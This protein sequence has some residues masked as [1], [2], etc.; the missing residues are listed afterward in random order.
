MYVVHRKSVQESRSQ[1][2][3]QQRQQQRQ[4]QEQ[5][6][7]SH[8]IPQLG[9]FIFNFILKQH[10]Q[11]QR[12]RQQE[13]REQQQ[14]RQQ[15]IQQQQQ[16]AR[17]HWMSQLGYF[18]ENFFC[19]IQSAL[20]IHSSYD[21]NYLVS[22]L[23]RVQRDSLYLF[24][25]IQISKNP[26]D[27]DPNVDPDDDKRKKKD[28]IE[29]ALTTN[30]LE[31]PEIQGIYEFNMNDFEFI[32]DIDVT[33]FSAVKKYLHKPSGQYIAIKYVNIPQQGDSYIINSNIG[34]IKKE[35][36][37]LK[38][39]RGYP[40]ITT[41]YGSFILDGRLLICMEYMDCSLED[42]YLNEH[43]ETGWFPEGFQGFI[44]FSMVNALDFCEQ[45]KIMHRDVK[46]RNILVKLTTSEIKLADFGVARLI[47]ESIPMS[48]K[49]TYLYRA[50]ELLRGQ[51]FSDSRHDVWSF[52]MTLV[53]ASNGRYPIEHN[54]NLLQLHD[55]I[56]NLHSHSFDPI[57][58][59]YS[60][61]FQY[62]IH[63][64]L[65]E[66]DTRPTFAE[67]R[68]TPFYKNFERISQGYD[69]RNNVVYE[70]FK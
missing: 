65:S 9:Y 31:I 44:I 20:D 29:K 58:K 22:E 42:F 21:T 7:R 2:Q 26:P 57:L 12:Q 32:E 14:Q 40:F 24:P 69:S 60:K 59:R 68:S 18:I 46:P 49:G 11:Q 43:R 1:Q 33:C 55:S 3:Q 10:R 67:L 52:G 13:Q 25:I 63:Q 34:D 17:S 15:K 39:V 41:L 62:F 8:W 35:V 27:I 38:L 19:W 50:P 54:E 5:Q 51:I 61:E 53:E 66:F 4:Q 37:F 36:E 64:C 56:L 45:L 23:D 48:I 47:R 28:D 30:E 6:D 70:L 16:Q